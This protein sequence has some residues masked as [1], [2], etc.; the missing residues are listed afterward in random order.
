MTNCK[1]CGA[2]LTETGKCEYCGTNNEQNT[3]NVKV[4]MDGQKIGA[5]V[6]PYI[7]KVIFYAD[8]KAIC[9]E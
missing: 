5:L 2:P 1:N 3:Q 9:E 6:E 4:V 8:D 7:S